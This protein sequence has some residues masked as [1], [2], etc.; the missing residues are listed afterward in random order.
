MFQPESFF[1]VT[2]TVVTDDFVVDASACG[3]GVA[4]ARVSAA[5]IA[6]IHLEVVRVCMVSSAVGC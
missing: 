1:A 3:A 6:P 2:T 4:N 5:A